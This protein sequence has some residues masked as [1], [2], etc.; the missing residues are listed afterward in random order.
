MNIALDYD[1]TYTED[2]ELWRNF[3][4]VAEQRGHQVM[5]VTSRSTQLEEEKEHC[6]KILADALTLG[7]KLYFTHKRSKVKH[8]EKLGIR[9]DV[10]IDNNPH[11]VL[12]GD[13]RE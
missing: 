10:W 2:P 12:L 8:M 3:I 7:I 13:I 9:I 5:F 11:S 6:K 1:E 4:S